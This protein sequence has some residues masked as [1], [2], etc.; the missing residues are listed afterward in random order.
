MCMNNLLISISID[1]NPKFRR[2]LRERL[3]GYPD[4]VKTLYEVVGPALAK[5][6]H[7]NRRREREEAEQQRTTTK[8]VSNVSDIAVE[9]KA[10]PAHVPHQSAEPALFDNGPRRS[11]DEHTGMQLDG[12]GQP[13][14][15][16]PITDEHLLWTTPLATTEVLGTTSGAPVPQPNTEEWLVRLMT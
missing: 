8:Y 13:D 1:N 12:Q 11:Y 7:E 15:Y 6:G 10:S 4:L 14:G 3:W 2:L 5:E 16:A 9:D